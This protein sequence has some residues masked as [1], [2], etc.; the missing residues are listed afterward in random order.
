MHTYVCV[1]LLLAPHWCTAVLDQIDT[2]RLRESARRC[3]HD[4]MSSG[5]ARSCAA[6]LAIVCFIGLPPAL[7]RSFMLQRGLDRR[8]LGRIAMKGWSDPDWNWGSPFGKAHD[9][10]MALRARLRT[11]P[12]R[13]TWIT[14]ALQDKSTISLDE[15]KLALCLRVQ[16]AARQ[17]IDGDGAGWQ[18]MCL[19]AECAYEDDLD[20][21]E[22]DIQSLNAR[23]G[24]SQGSEDTVRDGM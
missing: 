1:L 23:L 17:G 6:I 15:L 2:V 10:A 13:K 18:L 7:D 21:L 4:Q 20:R 24:D 16:H 14:A 19:M 5:V 3:T 11:E 22:A 9:E 12:T 8:D